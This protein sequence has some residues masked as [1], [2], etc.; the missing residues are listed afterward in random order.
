MIY[1][2]MCRKVCPN[3]MGYSHYFFTRELIY[4]FDAAPGYNWLFATYLFLVFTPIS[5]MME[6]LAT[7]TRHGPNL[8]F[9]FDIIYGGGS[10]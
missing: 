10:P 8:V 2:M 4:P 5:D 7:A 1:W 6:L 3:M 9:C